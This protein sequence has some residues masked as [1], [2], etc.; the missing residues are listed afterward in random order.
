VELSAILGDAAYRNQVKKRIC[1]AGGLTG[2]AEANLFLR[3]F[4]DSF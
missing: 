4:D 2:F 3:R 1:Y